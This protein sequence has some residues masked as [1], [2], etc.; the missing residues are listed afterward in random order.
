[1]TS[2]SRVPKN[3]MKGAWDLIKRK[4]TLGSTGPVHKY[5]GCNHVIKETLRNGKIKRTMSYD[6]TGFMKTC[7]QSYKDLC[8][9]PEMKL[10]RVETPFLATSVA[11]ERDYI[12]AG[13][14]TR[15][16]PS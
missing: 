8:G 10:R 14:I 5:L 13:T 6:M 11:P 2:S 7:V 4:I 1:M 12:E 16:I 3:N 9:D 15:A